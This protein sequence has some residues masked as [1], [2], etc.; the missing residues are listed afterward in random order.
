MAPC[1]GEEPRRSSGM[2]P[3]A[4]GQSEEM[5]ERQPSGHPP[6]YLKAQHTIG[7]DCAYYN[8]D[9][10][11]QFLPMIWYDQKLL[12]HSNLINI[13]DIKKKKKKKKK[14]KEKKKKKKKKSTVR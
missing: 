10:G 7:K 9:S 13:Y 2:P 5:E 4:P 8:L 1:R 14:K 12:I 11:N 6:N 3:P